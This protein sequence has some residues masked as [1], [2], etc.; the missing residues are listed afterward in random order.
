MCVSQQSPFQLNWIEIEIDTDRERQTDRHIDRQTV[1]QT[2]RE[3]ERECRSNHRRVTV[4]VTRVAHHHSSTVFSSRFELIGSQSAVLSSATHNGFRNTFWAYCSAVIL[5]CLWW[6][7]HVGPSQ[8]RIQHR[9][10]L[11][12]SFTDA[13]RE[14]VCHAVS[15]CSGNRQFTEPLR[16]L[17]D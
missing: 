9:P 14:C 7:S 11:Y 13:Q 10:N 8:K 16:P 15:L 1:R 5:D 12:V 2:E 6:G 4:L 3:R 17:P